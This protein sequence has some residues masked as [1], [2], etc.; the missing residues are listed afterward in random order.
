MRMTDFSNSEAV[1]RVY[2]VLEKM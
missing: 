2:D 1:A